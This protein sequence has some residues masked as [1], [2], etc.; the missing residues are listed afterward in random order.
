MSFIHKNTWCW[1]RTH[2][3]VCHGGR[4]IVNISI[5]NDNPLVA[6][7]HGVSVL[8]NNRENGIGTELIELAEREAYE[9]GA[10]RVCLATEPD[11][12][13]EKW[14]KRLG[15][16]FDSYN[17]DNLKVLVKELKLI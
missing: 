7:I 3:I 4:G 13:L 17:E 16:Q 1:G 12:W 6:T 10:S 15:Y 2:T 11:S 8:P 14:Y 9:M 5:E